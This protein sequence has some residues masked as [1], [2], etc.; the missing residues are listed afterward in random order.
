[1]K[2]TILVLIS[3]ILTLSGFQ[4]VFADVTGSMLNFKK[5]KTYTSGQFADVSEDD[6]YAENVKLRPL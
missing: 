3:L 2:K 5:T 1:M 6:W 4:T